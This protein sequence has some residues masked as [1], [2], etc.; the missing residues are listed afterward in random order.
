MKKIKSKLLTGVCLLVIGT[1]SLLGM[2]ACG[3]INPSQTKIAARDVYAI[4]A[5]SG[6]S[7]LANLENIPAQAMSFS[8]FAVQEVS[9]PDYITDEEVKGIKDCLFLF[10]D[11]LG[12][13]FSQTVKNN[14]NEEFANYSCVM[15]IS[16]GQS[17]SFLMYYN[18]IATETETEID[19]DDEEVE[20]STTLEG[21]L[22]VGD[23]TFDVSG[24][25]QVETENNE[26][27]TS[28][29]FTTKSKSNPLNYVTVCQSIE[30]NEVEFEYK[31]YKNGI[32]EQDLEIEIEYENGETE[33]EFS[34]KQFTDAITT[35]TKYKVSKK[36]DSDVYDIK[37]TRNEIKD[38]M[39]ATKT[40]DGYML[41]YSNGAIENV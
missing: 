38:T 7:Y 41:T 3:G 35:R 21:I 37:I 22:V 18:E 36:V 5:A 26:V 17:N 33:L 13:D 6:M 1:V 24:K 39:T 30:N 14:T 19:E 12:T 8:S 15:T 9:R 10:D 20:V 27:E 40:I 11:M 31:I 28:I 32:K 34:L 16:L 29:E 2:S 23:L 25:R 4:S